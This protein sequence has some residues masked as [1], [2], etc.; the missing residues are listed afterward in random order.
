M[1]DKYSG[2]KH[3]HTKKPLTNP[4]RF[5]KGVKGPM[6]RPLTL[7]RQIKGEE[8]RG[9]RRFPRSPNHPKE[10]NPNIERS[11]SWSSKTVVLLLAS[12][13]T[14]KQQNGQGP[15]IV[16]LPKRTQTRQDG[17]FLQSLNSQ[18]RSRE[19]LPSGSPRGGGSTNLPPPVPN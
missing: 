10:A 18:D 6:G 9:T 2:M 17:S 11:L 15:D 3:D 13:T 5:H 16:V 1:T 12:S 8:H 4:R 19:L 7:G 14:S